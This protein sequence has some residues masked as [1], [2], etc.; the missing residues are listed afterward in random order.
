M[1]ATLTF[2]GLM[3]TALSWAQ[4]YIEHNIPKILGSGNEREVDIVIHRP[5]LKGFSQYEISFQPGI[6]I[7]SRNTGGG[8]F[9]GEDNKVRVIWSIT[10][11][12]QLRLRLAI[13]PATSGTYVLR[14]R[15]EYE[16]G[17][18]RKVANIED[19][20]IEVRNGFISGGSVPFSRLDQVVPRE[21]PLSH[22]DSLEKQLQ[23][24]AKAVEHAGQLRRDATEARKVGQ[25]E[26][27]EAELEI[28]EA[29][30]AIEQ[31][32]RNKDEQV[33][34]GL[35]KEGEER[36]AKAETNKQIANKILA[37]A[38]SLEQNAAD[39]EKAGLAA[40]ND[41][42]QGAKDKKSTD[43]IAELKKMFDN[44]NGPPSAAEAANGAAM[45]LYHIQIG[46]FG[47][48]P[49]KADYRKAGKISVVN[50]KGLYK[51]LVG[52]FEKR[53]DAERKRQE[54]AANGFD[55]FIVRYKGDERIK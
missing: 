53:E 7:S 45:P 37:L 44:S 12:G 42:A 27:R 28:K 34:A 24:P 19:L 26:L 46:A 13:M 40:R 15:Y 38:N 4:V 20:S 3:M 6:A 36:L 32:S 23:D 1:K 50:E 49:V 25:N 18:E 10:P 22:V 43:E 54:L 17:G 51:V 16:Q 35:V 9:R 33:K 5:A 52:G 21:L 48:P 55:G 39:I 11:A 14:Q 2:A 31:A 30:K 41:S 47:Q 8:T 29:K